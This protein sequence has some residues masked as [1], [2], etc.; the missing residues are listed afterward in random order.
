MGI[1]RVAV[2]VRQ[3]RYTQG[4][5]LGDPLTIYPSIDY[6]AMVVQLGRSCLLYKRDLRRACRQIYV[7]EIS[8]SS[9]SEG[10][11]LITQMWRS[12]SAFVVAR[13][14]VTDTFTVRP[15]SSAQADTEPHPALAL[16]SADDR[17]IPIISIRSDI[18]RGTRLHKTQK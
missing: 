5:M 9:V 10:T 2:Y 13:S 7:L 17:R 11:A 12:C 18:W 6:T 8:T 4:H 16:Q 1:V 3:R 15:V 14:C